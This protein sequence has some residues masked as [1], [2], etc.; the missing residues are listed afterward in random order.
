MEPTARLFQR[1]HLQLDA[2]LAGQLLL[3]ITAQDS[4]TGTAVNTTLWYTISYNAL[5]AVS[6]SFAP[7]SPQPAYTPITITAAATGG[8]NVQYQF[9]VYNPSTP[10]WSQLQGYSSAA[11][12]NW[13]P[14]LAGNYYLSI[15]AQ[16]AT[17]T[18]VNDAVW[19]TVTPGTPP[20]V[21][22][23]FTVQAASWAAYQDGSRP[24]Q[25]L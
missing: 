3:S 5:T 17:G 8:T 20:T 7:A 6:V 11:T 18:A 1:G 25:V 15:T 21:T 4:V 23:P 12:C 13:T 9:W 22:I 16:D 10:A 19:Y 14:T 2:G 24:W